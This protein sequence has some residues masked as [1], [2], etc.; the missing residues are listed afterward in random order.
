[1]P[2]KSGKKGSAS[3]GKGEEDREEPLQAILLADDYHNRFEPFTLEHPRC[4]LKLANTPLIEYTLEWL[5]SV[6]V[7]QVFLYSGNHTDQVEQYLENS[8]WTR[9]PSPLSLD[10]IRSTATSVGDA[11]RD[12]DQ[13]G[14]IKG[15]FI[16]VYGDVVANIPLQGALAAH[17]ARREKNKNAIM[18]M[19]LREASGYRPAQLRQHARQ[20]FV[21]DPETERCIHYES[22]RPG[23]STR[24]NVPGEVLK[25]HVESEVRQDLVDCG[26]DICAPDVLA[27]WSDSFDW[28][29]PR[30]DFVHGVLQDF[31]TFGRMIHTFVF[32]EGYAARVHNLKAY[33]SVSNDVVSRWAYPYAPDT[34]LLSDQSFQLQKGGVYKEDGVVLARS[35]NVGRRSVLG[36]ATSIGEGSTV[37]NSVIGRRCVIGSRVRIENAYIWD[38]AHIGN[39]SVVEHAI[40]ASEASVGKRCRVKNGALVSYGVR[41]ADETVVESNT[42]V[43]RLKRKRG[44]DADEL[45]TGVT[46]PKVV[47]EGGEGFELE[48]DAEEEE[49]AEALL[50]GMQNI[51]LAL[52]ED[53]ISDFEDESDEDGFDHAQPSSRSG[54]FASIGSDESGETRRNAADFHHE[55]ANSIFDSLQKQEDPDTIQMELKALRMSSN[56]EDKQVRRAVAVAFGKRIANLIESGKSP[57]DAVAAAIP[58]N[59]RLITACVKEAEEQAEFLLFLQI[60]LVHRPQGNKILVFAA[61]VLAENDLVDGDGLEQWWEDERSSASE[62]LKDVRA[63]TKAVVDIMAGDS[64]DGEEEEETDD[65]DDD[66]E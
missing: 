51:D 41:I 25:D 31:E 49:V 33:D 56:A 38:D 23:Q 37:M 30:Q 1:M 61:N 19:V 45:I 64:D 57:K 15:D 28:K 11:M 32:T 40:V 4:L 17:K 55:A 39:D 14:L 5:A 18:T 22:S 16:A 59:Q 27:Q 35:S 6:G 52:D 34:N 44:Y 42:R 10:I 46:D 60:D 48:L 53:D 29:V 13:K 3:K 43:T 8:R 62:E 24:L 26:I 58:K 20:C 36:K 47:G 7:E 2:P 12:I 66:D 54:S 50:A 65:D 63:D 21:I 9:D